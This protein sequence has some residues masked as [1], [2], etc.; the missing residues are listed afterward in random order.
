M[1]GFRWVD[2]G[3]FSSGEVARDG[4]EF[5]NGG[6]VKTVVTLFDDNLGL[7]KAELQGMKWDCC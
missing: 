7:V 5:R 6:V 3:G 1:E 4:E 2:S